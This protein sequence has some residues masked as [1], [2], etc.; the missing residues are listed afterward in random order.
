MYRLYTE[1]SMTLRCV[2]INQLSEIERT[3]RLLVIIDHEWNGMEFLW[4]FK[5]KMDVYQIE[6]IPYQTICSS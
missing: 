2:M 1:H 6:R 4:D 3:S 5:E